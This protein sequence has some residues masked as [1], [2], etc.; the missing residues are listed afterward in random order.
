[1]KKWL[2]FAMCAVLVICTLAG[3]SSGKTSDEQVGKPMYLQFPTATTSGAIYPIGAAIAEL[4]NKNIDGVEVS[5]E[6]SNGG[7]QNLGL[8]S[9][10]DAQVS[11]A[12][13]SIITEQ[14]QGIG[15]FEGRSY[16]G[17][18]ILSAL[19]S[20]YNQVVSTRDSGVNSMQDFKGK[21]FAPGA[22]GSTPEVETGIY[23]E[24][25]GMNY[26]DDI[27]AQFVGFT[28]A[29]DLM[30][31][32]QLEG[33][34]IQAGL[35]TAA[36]S[37]M[38]ATANGKLISFDEDVI[39]KLVEQYPWYNRAIIPAGTYDGQDEDVVTTSIVITLMVDESVPEDTVY[40]MTKVLWENIDSLR[41]THNALKE[42]SIENAVKNLAGLPLHDGAKKYYEEVGVL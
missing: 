35:P 20:N 37:E 33:A 12:V 2:V 25:A 15:K 13:T 3:C 29:V 1:M 10:G 23:F 31:N 6:A 26:P 7:V 40:E 34:W 30:R 27:K 36:V 24:I 21:R 39:E 19:Y 5:A 22:S 11:V 4:W 28:E 41:N 16:D 32:K 9:T 38:C 14:K 42:M 8:M 18:R 17:V